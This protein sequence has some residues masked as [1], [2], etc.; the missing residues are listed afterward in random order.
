[1]DGSNAWPFR[2]DL[3]VKVIQK[4]QPELIGLQEALEIQI[5]DL[6]KGLPQYAVVGTGRMNGRTGNEFNPIFYNT[7]RL[8]LLRSDTFWLSDTPEVPGSVHWDNKI[9]RICTWAYFLDLKTGKCFYH[10]NTHF[11]HIG[12]ESREKSAELLVRKAS[13]VK[14]RD[15]IVMT[16]DFNAGEK[17]RAIRAIRKAGFLDSF[18]V[19]NPHQKEVGTTTA[20]QQARHFDKI[21]YIFID[22]GWTVK[23]SAILTDKFDDKWPSDHLPIIATLVQQ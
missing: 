21:D 19:V 13:Q 15:S 20:F 23:S 4:H 17:N 10:F 9:V 3:V 5:T 6:I 22:K 14:P 12:Q 18:R 11:D 1:M 16:G 8:Q 2:K 7:S